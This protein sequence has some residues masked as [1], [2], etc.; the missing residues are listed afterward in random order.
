MLSKILNPS[1][2]SRRQPALDVSTGLP[3][4]DATEQTRR[5]WAQLI[6][7][8]D[9]VPDAYEDFFEPARKTGLTFP[10]TV[11]TPSHEGFIHRY[12][13]QLTCML[14]L[15]VCVL[16]KCGSTFSAQCYPLEAISHVEVSAVLLDSQVTIT[17]LTTSGVPSVSTLRFNSVTDYLFA[18][19]V[20]RIRLRSAGSRGWPVRSDS[21]A[22]DQ[23]RYSNYKFMNYAKRS[24]LG[25]EKVMHA[26]LQPEIRKHEFTL[27]G[28]TFSRL[29]SPTQASILTDRELILILEGERK[30]GGEERY[31]GTWHFIPLN[32][33]E[34]LL[35]SPKDETTWTLHVRAAHASPVECLYSSSAETDLRQ[36]IDRFEGLSG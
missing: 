23:W 12:S 7:S 22:F 6:G 4:T 30:R 25:D 28:R 2:F 24:L 1:R 8:F 27:L 35:A 9:Q 31:G 36:F 32:K 15:E 20:E 5:S 19:V 17:G 13:E 21:E 16:E 10:Y 33:I 3:V 34:T 18:P 26:I 14:G 29:I 11:L